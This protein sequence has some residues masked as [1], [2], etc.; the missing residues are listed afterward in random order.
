VEKAEQRVPQQHARPC[1]AHHRLD[2]FAHDSAVAVDLAMITGG[3]GLLEWAG[4]QTPSGVVEEDGA[5]SAESTLPAVMIPAVD[6]HHGLDGLFLACDAASG[7][8]HVASF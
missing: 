5:I 8:F 2:P 6:V 3:L 4:I 1:I 7:G